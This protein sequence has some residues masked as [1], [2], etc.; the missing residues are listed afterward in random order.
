MR[1]TAYLSVV[2]SFLF[3]TAC[4]HP[5]VITPNMG[6]L[7]A[8]GTNKINKNVGYYIPA[9]ERDKRVETPGGGGDKLSYTPYKDLEPAMQKTLANVFSDV[10]TVNSLEDKAFLQAKKISYVFVPKIETESSSESAFTWPPTKFTVSLECAALDANGRE[11][12]RKTTKQSGE[13]TF[14]EFKTDFPLAGKR[15]A[16]KAFQDMQK[17]IHTTPAFR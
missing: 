3:L 2:L 9:A 8:N 6:E 7:N 16:L 4:A 10:Y 13:A 1:R 17:T 11:I 15:A 14:S 12:W 5:I